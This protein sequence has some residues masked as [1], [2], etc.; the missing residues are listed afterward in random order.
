MPPDGV[1]SFLLA[2]AKGGLPLPADQPGLVPL[3]K[4]NSVLT[5]LDLSGAEPTYGND[6]RGLVALGEALASPGTASALV[7]VTVTREVQ[8]EVGGLA[9]AESLDWAGKEIGHLEWTFAAGIVRG[10]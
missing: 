7:E 9:T 4:H 1:A 8:L 6:L 5:L 10:R 3:L 2:K